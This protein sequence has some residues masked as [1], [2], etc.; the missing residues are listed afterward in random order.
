MMAFPMFIV[1]ILTLVILVTHMQDINLVSGQF[2]DKFNVLNLHQCVLMSQ[3]NL[4]VHSDQL[5]DQP[6]LVHVQDKIIDGRFV[7][8]LVDVTKY[9]YRVL[10]FDWH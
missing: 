6:I 7:V 10:I 3:M 5:L 4:V 9:L 1:L 8:I 2:D